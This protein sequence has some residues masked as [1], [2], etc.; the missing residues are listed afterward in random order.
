[1]IAQSIIYGDSLRSCVVAIIVPHLDKVQAWSK[2]NGN[3]EQDPNQS[4]KDTAFK[5]LI[6][7][8]VLRICAEQKLSGL[9]RP[10]D[11]FITLETFSVENNLLTPTFKLKRNVA[12][13]YFKKHID[14]MY[15]ALIK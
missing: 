15:S 9:E 6:F 13:D 14:D 3:P 7:D 2:E 8:E 12:R 4:I 5:K 11:I 1:M 10:K